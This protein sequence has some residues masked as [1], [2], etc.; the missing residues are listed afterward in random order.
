MKRHYIRL[1]TWCLVLLSAFLVV[2]ILLYIYPRKIIQ[3]TGLHA[4][5]DSYSIGDTVVIESH[6][7]FFAEGKSTN[8]IALKCGATNYLISTVVIPVKPTL[9]ALGKPGPVHNAMPIG[10][11]PDGVKASPPTC[12]IRITTTYTIRT[13]L[14]FT[15]DYVT[16]LDSNEFKIVK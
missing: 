14:W 13:F 5:Q 16:V 7:Q 6:T 12:I 4:T 2:A 9:T 1:I 15:R 8:V 10:V 3:T 11:I